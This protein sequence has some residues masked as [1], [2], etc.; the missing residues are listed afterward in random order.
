M[1][2]FNNK[3]FKKVDEIYNFEIKDEKTLKVREKS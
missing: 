1:E 3:D 2:L